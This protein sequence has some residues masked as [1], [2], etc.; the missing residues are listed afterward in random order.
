MPTTET[1][2]L[3]LSR[4]RTPYG[5]LQI[6]QH[7]LFS[8]NATFNSWGI[9]IDPQYLVDRI[10]NGNGINRDTNYYENRQAPGDDATKDEWLSETDNGL[11]SSGP[12]GAALGATT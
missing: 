2:G 1:Y 9:V 3:M 5:F 10:L 12:L 7:P 6:L 11:S 4:Y 8:K